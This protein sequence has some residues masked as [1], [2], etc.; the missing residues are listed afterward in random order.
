MKVSDSC[1]IQVFKKEN[2]DSGLTFAYHK[3][4]IFY[5][6]KKLLKGEINADCHTY[7]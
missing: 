1:K 2:L 7:Q 5:F 6:G 3:V 4:R